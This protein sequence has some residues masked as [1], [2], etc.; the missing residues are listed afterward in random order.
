LLSI[1]QNA[2]SATL[3]C[4]SMAG[5]L[6]T[7][8]RK[9]GACAPSNVVSHLQI[10]VRARALALKDRTWLPNLHALLKPPL[11]SSRIHRDFYD[12]LELEMPRP[13]TDSRPYPFDHKQL[14]PGAEEL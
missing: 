4:A 14:H 11:S 13:A 2:V 1:S 3:S 9:G 7:A 8:M 6:A 5:R 12:F 10:V